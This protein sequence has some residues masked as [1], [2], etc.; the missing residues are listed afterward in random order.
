MLTEL[1]ARELDLNRQKAELSHEYGPR[2]PQMV[3]LEAQLTTLADR[4]R[5]EIKQIAQRLRDEVQVGRSREATLQSNIE[6]I[7]AQL[8]R[9][10]TRP[11]S[12][13]R[14]CSAK[15]PPTATCLRP[16]STEPRRSRHSRKRRS[17]MPGSSRARFCPTSRPIRAAS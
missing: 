5:A 12:G 6:S 2:H 16:T 14:L 15:R 3:N 7:K 11:R 10:I 17:R 9:S 8:A 1:R 4:K 13:S